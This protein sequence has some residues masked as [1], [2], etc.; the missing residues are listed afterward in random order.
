MPPLEAKNQ[1]TLIPLVKKTCIWAVVTTALYIFSYQYLDI[2]I[3][4][5]SEHINSHMLILTAR[6]FST[7]FSPESWVILT[8]ICTVI[9]FHTRKKHNDKP[10]KKS[11]HQYL[12]IITLSLYIAFI[13]NIILKITIGRYRPEYMVTESLYGFHPFRLTSSSSPSG[14]ASLAF[15]GLLAITY[16]LN[17]KHS[18]LIG[19]I[20]AIVVSI[21]R[22]ILEKHYLAD[23]ILGAYI[24]CFSFYWAQYLSNLRFINNRSL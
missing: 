24:G 3:L 23:L 6:I 13:I 22:I 20:I 9:L 15:S 16:S 19:L 21:S 8:V 17:R 12:L 14:H 1:E 7:I 2:P 11:Q 5:L 4:Q 10:R 18:I